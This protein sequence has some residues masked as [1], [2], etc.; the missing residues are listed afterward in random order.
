MSTDDIFQHAQSVKENLS[1]F[2][3][4]FK[5]HPSAGQ[6]GIL[7]DAVSNLPSLVKLALQLDYKDVKANGVR[8]LIRS[9]DNLSRT[10]LTVSD[11]EVD[12]FLYLVSYLNRGAD[13]LLEGCEDLLN[14][15]FT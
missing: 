12:D 13:L 9:C 7:D 1:Q 2:R 8:S 15:M 3:N 10:A 6:F 4:K 5:A 11:E 14:G